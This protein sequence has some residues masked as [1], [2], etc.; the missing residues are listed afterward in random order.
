MNVSNILPSI[1]C[2]SVNHFY[3]SLKPPEMLCWRYYKSKKCCPKANGISIGKGTDFSNGKANDDAISLQH[4]YHGNKSCLLLLNKKMCMPATWNS[5]L[6]SWMSSG[7]MCR[8]GASCLFS[9]RVAKLYPP[10]LW[11]QQAVGLLCCW[12]LCLGLTKRKP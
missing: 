12:R 10:D 7:I 5:A 8:M 6:A 2:C 11:A 4:Y 1:K 9:I 3:S